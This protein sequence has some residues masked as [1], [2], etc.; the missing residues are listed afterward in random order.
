MGIMK[1]DLMMIQNWN[2]WLGNSKP[3]VM[4][5]SAIPLSRPAPP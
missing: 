3:H 1:I 2:T 4:F 5:I